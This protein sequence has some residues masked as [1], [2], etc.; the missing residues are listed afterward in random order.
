MTPL[1]DSRAQASAPCFPH[2]AHSPALCSLA[3]AL[4]HAPSLSSAR[5][6][7]RPLPSLTDVWTPPVGVLPPTFL[8]PPRRARARVAGEITGIAFPLFRAAILGTLPLNHPVTLPC[9]PHHH[10]CRPEP[11]AP[12]PYSAPP[13]PVRCATVNPSPRCTSAPANPRRRSAVTPRRFPSRPSSAPTSATPESHPRSTAAGEA[14]S[15]QLLATGDA[16]A[17]LTPCLPPQPDHAP[18][19]VIR[20]PGAA[21][22]RP[23]HG[24]R[25]TLRHPSS[26]PTS[27]CCASGHS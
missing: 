15:E 24:V 16:L 4:S 5:S 20:T 21:P 10:D 19:R 25:R 3:A 26:P 11:H 23:L 13:C 27:L 7:A 12:L 22:P 1:A 18:V 9:A 2:A 14:A 17:P 6:P 8:S